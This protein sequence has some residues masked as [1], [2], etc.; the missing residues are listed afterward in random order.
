MKLTSTSEFHYLYDTL[1]SSHPGTARGKE[2]LLPLF[3]P[4]SMSLGSALPLE[5]QE[6][7]P[8]IFLATGSILPSEKQQSGLTC[9]PVTLALL[10]NPSFALLNSITIIYERIHHKY[11]V[12]CKEWTQEAVLEQVKARGTNRLMRMSKS[13]RG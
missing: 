10:L 3:H 1:A 5:Y 7:V 9:L 6:N 11:S 2:M 12:V 4:S 13:E 8:L